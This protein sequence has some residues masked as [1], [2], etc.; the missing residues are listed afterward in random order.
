[1]TM[2]T[3]LWRF[4]WAINLA[5]IALCAVLVAHATATLL[6]VRIGRFTPPI[7][8]AAPATA[9]ASNPAKAVDRILGRNIFCS[10]CPGISADVMLGGSPSPGP[11]ARRTTLP[12]RLLAVMFAPPPHTRWSVAVIRDVLDRSVGPHTIG[13]AI[14]GAVISAIEETRLFLEIDGR[15]EYLDLLSDVPADQMGPGATTAAASPIAAPP[16]DPLAAVVER[17]IRR[18]GEHNYEVQRQAVDALLGNMSAL[19]RSV[20]VIPEI[21]EG[22]AA[23]FR[24]LGVVPDG[25]LAKVGLRNG[26]VISAI[27]GFEMTAS[28]K[29]LEAYVKVKS[30]S[31]LSLALERAGQRI[32]LEY[33]IR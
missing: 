8:F 32:S 31:H 24:L 20:R 3:L 21:R 1:V 13:S 12:L 9:P 5:V 28:D 26:D 27:N 4:S 15:T 17:G 33:S 16:T 19:S 25:L 6:R 30:A 22:R 10:T 14:R 2:E 11:D 7:R 23:G 18:I 29:A